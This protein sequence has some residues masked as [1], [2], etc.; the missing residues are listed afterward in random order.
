LDK[1]DLFIGQKVW[2]KPGRNTS[3]RINKTLEGEIIKVGRKYLYVTVN[4]RTYKYDINTFEQVTDYIADWYLYFDLQQILDEE[5]CAKLT[6][7]IRTA[8]SHDNRQPD[9]TI[10]QLR[11]IHAIIYPG[12]PFS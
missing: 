1:K 9:L 12:Q 11:Q 8:L 3:R 2:M 4:S 7:E 10:E 6:S 5:E